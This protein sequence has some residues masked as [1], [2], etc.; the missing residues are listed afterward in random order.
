MN[1]GNESHIILVDSLHVLPAA[2]VFLFVRKNVYIRVKL[3]ISADILSLYSR[4]L[5]K[6]LSHEK[7]FKKF[8]RNVQ[9]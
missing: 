6:R 9:N 7:D 3:G 5:L 2:A 4:R 1:A 8:N